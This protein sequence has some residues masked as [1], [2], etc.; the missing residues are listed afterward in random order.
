M[1][2][3][4]GRNDIGKISKLSVKKRCYLCNEERAYYENIKNDR[5]VKGIQKVKY[6]MREYAGKGKYIEELL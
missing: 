2:V 5:Y 4:L 6:V 1:L 3:D